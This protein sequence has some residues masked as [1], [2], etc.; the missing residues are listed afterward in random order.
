MISAIPKAVYAHSFIA[1]DVKILQKQ[2]FVGLLV[3]KDFG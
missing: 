1:R 2:T 3:Y